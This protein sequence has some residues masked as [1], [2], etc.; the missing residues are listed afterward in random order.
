MEEQLA[1]DITADIIGK[2]TCAYK[3][4]KY[5]PGGDNQ[6]D[7]KETDEAN[8]VNQDLCDEVVINS[9]ESVITDNGVG[10]PEEKEKDQVCIKSYILPETRN[11]ERLKKDIAVS[12]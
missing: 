8:Q 10:P 1:V 4:K 9:Q 12:T 11:S 5:G 3:E 7:S 2:Q 6:V